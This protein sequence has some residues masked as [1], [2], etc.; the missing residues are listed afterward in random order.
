MHRKISVTANE[1]LK[2]HADAWLTHGIV[3][4]VL[5]HFA[6]FTFWP[7][8]TVADYRPDRDE[9]MLVIPPELDVPAPPEQLARPATPVISSADID[10]SVTIA[11]MPLEAWS[12][13][14]LAPPTRQPG[15]TRQFEAWVPSMV[16]PSILNRTAVERALERNYPPLLRDAGIGG[17]VDVNIWLDADGS[18]V[19]AEVARGSGYPDLDAAALKV[20]DVMR[21]SPAYNRGAT[22]RVVVTLPVVFMAR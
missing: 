6:A 7:A 18:I 15:E 17:R 10:E 11:P 8:L 9:T 14:R 21:L 22:V 12:V 16:A 19:R 2:V 3:L 4:S 5:V 20:V 1:R 13:D